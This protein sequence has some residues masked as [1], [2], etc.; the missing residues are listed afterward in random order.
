MS[1]RLPP[2]FEIVVSPAAPP[3]DGV[4]MA[5]AGEIDVATAPEFEAALRER[6]AAAPVRLDL[7]GLS[8]MASSGIRVLDAILRDVAAHRW[9]LVIEPTMQ[10]AV[11]QILA[12]TGMIDA[13]PFDA[14]READP[15]P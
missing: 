2:S 1:A 3:R 12:L 13:L 4:V 5:V 10:P 15:L 9:A 14:P 7:R 8:F 6:L 11:R